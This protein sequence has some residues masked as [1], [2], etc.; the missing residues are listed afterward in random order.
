MV[1]MEIDFRGALEEIRDQRALPTCLAHATS[2]VHRHFRGL[3]NRLSAECLH[4]HSTGGDWLSGVTMNSL[5]KTLKMS[6]QPEE[7]K[8]DPL[9]LRNPDGW[10]PPTDVQFYRIESGIRSAQSQIVCDAIRD[11]DLPILGIGM[12]DEFLDP[13]PPWVISAGHSTR[14]LHAVL[15]VG[16]G[17]FQQ[18]TVVLIR[19]SWGEDWADSGH[20]WIDESFLSN[21]LK[22]V[23]VL[24]GGVDF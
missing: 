1:E 13:D 18:E 7:R 12:P 9:S 15:G 3:D 2:T 6:G 22:D 19:N 17:Q 14:D 10:S 8:C 20:A 11:S 5:Q 23:L 21:H 24:E 16:L 4:Y